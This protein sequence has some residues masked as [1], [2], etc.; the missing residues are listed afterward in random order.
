MIA[1]L[2]RT[3]ILPRTFIM[4]PGESLLIAGVAQIDVISLPMVVK[5][6]SDKDYRERRPCVLVSPLMEFIIDLPTICKVF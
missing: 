4:H 5:P 3:M 2:P 1:V 6:G